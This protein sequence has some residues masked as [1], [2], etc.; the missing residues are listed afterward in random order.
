MSFLKLILIILAGRWG[1]SVRAVGDLSPSGSLNL[2]NN[3]SAVDI[4]TV[5]VF[6]EED[7]YFTT[8]KRLAAAIDLSVSHTNSYILPPS[9]QLQTRYQSTGSSCTQAEYAATA[10][11]YDLMHVQGVK[12][13]IFYGSSKEF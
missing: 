2:G 3:A 13:D 10:A 1:Q 8:Y 7:S 4:V 11:V 12:C 6:V 9:I 5:C